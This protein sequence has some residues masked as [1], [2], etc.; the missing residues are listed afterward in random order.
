MQFLEKAG[1][2]V[3]SESKMMQPKQ[4]SYAAEQ[5]SS[6]RRKQFSGH[7]AEE[8]N[9]LRSRLIAYY[10]EFPKNDAFL[11]AFEEALFFTPDEEQRVYTRILMEDTNTRLVLLGLHESQPFPVHDHAGAAACHAILHGCLRVR[12]YR[13]ADFI[14]RAMVRLECVSDRQANAGELDYVDQERAIHG[15]E[16]LSQRTLLLNLQSRQLDSKERHWY[17]PASMQQKNKQ[18]WFRIRRK[19]D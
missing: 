16:S 8:L 10:D 19:Q 12:H 15:L 6:A 7:V 14:N 2:F 17:F 3:G 1:M 9:E 4:F 13:E 11:C 18:I 5:A